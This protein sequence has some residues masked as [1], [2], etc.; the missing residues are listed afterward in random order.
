MGFHSLLLR[1]SRHTGTA[2]LLTPPFVDGMTTRLSRH[3][4]FSDATMPYEKGPPEPRPLKFHTGVGTKYLKKIKHINQK[5]RE[6]NIITQPSLSSIFR[7]SFSEF[8]PQNDTKNEE[9]HMWL[10]TRVSRPYIVL[11]KGT[12]TLRPFGLRVG[13]R[14]HH[15]VGGRRGRNRFRQPGRVDTP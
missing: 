4:I 11:F 13:V 7:C 15:S 9:S 12:K 2:W 5:P 6:I 14:Q 10:S 1:A 3:N 8:F